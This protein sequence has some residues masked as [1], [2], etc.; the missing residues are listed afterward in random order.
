MPKKAREKTATEV[1]RLKNPGLY[2]IGGV[3]GLQLQVSPSG[4]RSWVLRTLVGHRRRDIGLGGFPDVPLAQARERAREIK[5]QIRKGID[6]I[7]ER[8]AARHALRTSQVKQISFDEA[9]RRCHKAKAPEFKNGKHKSQWIGTLETYASPIIGRLPVSDIQLP[10]VLQVLEPI[11]HTKTET[12]SRVRQRIEAVLTWAT[13]SGFRSG[14]NPA[15]WLGKLKEELT[16]ARKIKPVNHHTAL[17]W[18]QVGAFMA[19]LRKREGI[20]ARAL[21]FAVLTAA[22]SGEA[23][24]MTWGEVDLNTKV[25]TVPPTRIKAGK[26]HNVPL[27]A[28]AVKLLNALPV[29]ENNPYVFPSPRGGMLSD[30]AMTAVLRRMNVEAVPHGFRSTF[31]D[32]ARSRTNYPD[33]VSE[34]AL[35]HVNND[36][37]RSA[38]ARDELLPKRAQLMR[39]WAKFCGSIQ[40]PGKVIQMRKRS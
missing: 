37:T 25:W 20:A 8:K 18:Q 23:R 1:R 38:Y 39:D 36:A 13:V 24:G 16:A 21:E 9:A 15:R 19:D 31:K 5:D 2:S 11:W 30:V 4:A 32:W 12:A 10:H 26:Q 28:D 17:P 35:A 7:A 6:P 29:F 34:L 22:R 14:E 3:S 27:S 40:K 33:E